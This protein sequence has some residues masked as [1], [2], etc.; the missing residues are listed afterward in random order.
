MIVR[1]MRAASPLFLVLAMMVGGAPAEA[2]N[3]DT[4]PYFGIRAI[5]AAFAEMKNVKT[6]GF[7]GTTNVEHDKDEVAGPAVVAGWRFKNFPLRT[8]LEAGYRVRFDFDVRDQVPGAVV[9]YE[10]NVATTQ[11]LIN[12]VY[13]WRN[14]S[15][16]TPFFGGTVGWAR[17]SAD[18]KRGVLGSGI[19]VNKT[20]DQDNIAYGALAGVDWH[21]ANNWSAEIAYRFINLGEVKTPTFSTGEQISADYYFS[22][23]VLLSL[24]YRF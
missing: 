3:G 8:E 10:M 7:G 15:S 2:S 9:D 12:A 22:H 21:F 24:F 18:S 17:N 23:D 5:G 16:F 20:Q 11:V 6:T 13:E 4:G 1:F 14:S 19:Q